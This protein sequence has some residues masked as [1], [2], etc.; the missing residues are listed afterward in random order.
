MFFVLPRT[1]GESAVTTVSVTR[2]AGS[3]QSAFYK[4]FP[5]VEA[6]I[7]KDSPVNGTS[8]TVFRPMS[9]S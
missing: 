1:G 5:N 6:C 9:D 4:H 7:A 2:A 3:A 8:S